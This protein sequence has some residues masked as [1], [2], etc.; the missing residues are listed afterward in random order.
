MTT[1]K[2]QKAG[3]ADSATTLELIAE[4]DRL[5]EALRYLWNEADVE[6]VVA[7][8]DGGKVRDLFG[9]LA[10]PMVEEIEELL[11]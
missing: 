11:A 7:A 3:R 5:R 6:V 8:H 10:D 1:L 4:R 2:P 9:G